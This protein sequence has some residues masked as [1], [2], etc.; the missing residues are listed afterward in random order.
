[1]LLPGSVGRPAPRLE[2]LSFGSRGRW[3]DRPWTG[4][5]RRGPRV[6]LVVETTG[7]EVDVFVLVVVDDVDVGTIDVDVV[8]C[9]VEV[10]ELAAFDVEVVLEV[11]DVV[12]VVLREV[13]V[14]VEPASVVL[15]VEGW[16]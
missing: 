3:R 2:R 7:T 4:A 15:V 14:V 1:M 9:V 6:V 13:V 11:D 12:V 8:T 16:L 5:P 10:V